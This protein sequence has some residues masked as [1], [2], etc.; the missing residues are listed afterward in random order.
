MKNVDSVKFIIKL[1]RVLWIA[2]GWFLI[3]AIDAVF[4][5]AVSDNAFIHRTDAYRFFPVLLANSF[6]FGF[7]GLCIGFLLIFYLKDKFRDQS[8]AYFLLINTA[9]ILAIAVLLNIFG[10]HL[11]FSTQLNRPFSHPD[12]WNATFQIFFSPI[13]LKNLAF[14]L[15]L[16]LGTIMTIQINEKYGPG[17]FLDLMIGKYHHAIEEER[18]FMFLDMKS[19][20][21]IAEQIGHLQFH[22]LLSES[23][24]DMTDPIIYTRGEINQYVGDEVIVSWKMQDGLQDAACVR[25]FFDIQE[26]IRRR[27]SE[28]LKKYG[29]VPE[30]KAGLHFGNV[31]VGEIG[32]VKRDIVF[33]GDVLNATARI[34]AHCNEAGVHILL[35]EHLLQQLD[36]SGQPYTVQQVG[37]FELKGK[38]EKMTLYTVSEH[39]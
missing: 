33:S 31:T 36:L 2:L 25:C 26:S 11:Y 28:Y 30:F 34:Q 27:K 24:S 3:G 23:F 35:S 38:T 18:I 9:L 8:Y 12:T 14:G 39:P 10:L 17:V 15:L 32:I 37:E 7:S 21:T 4:L 16:S 13:N 6:G 1:R 20:T 29:L 22:E 5:H 19:S